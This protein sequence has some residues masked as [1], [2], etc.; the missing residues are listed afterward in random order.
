MPE[1]LF[2][3]FLL[4]VLDSKGAKVCTSCRSWQELSNECLLAKFGVDAAENG[5]LTFCEK[6]AKSYLK[7][8]FGASQ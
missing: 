6:L 4:L 1:A 2:M 3:V 5:P 7:P 8:P